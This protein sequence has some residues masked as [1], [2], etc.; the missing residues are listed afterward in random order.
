MT[1]RSCTKLLKVRK[2]LTTKL[3]QHINDVVRLYYCPGK[4]GHFLQGF[5]SITDPRLKFTVTNKDFN[6][7][8]CN[9]KL[10]NFDN[11]GFVTSVL[12]C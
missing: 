6:V 12:V 4:L 8:F 2:P 3:T 7:Y 10:S 5:N 9:H 11:N 1:Y